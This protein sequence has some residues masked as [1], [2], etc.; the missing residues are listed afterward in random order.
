[1]LSR[2]TDVGHVGKFV[3]PKARVVIDDANSVQRALRQ[4]ITPT[5]IND[6]HL[7][8]A[9]Q[10]YT[11]YQ[12]SVLSPIN[13]RLFDGG[14]TRSSRIHLRRPDSEGACPALCVVVAAVVGVHD[15]QREAGGEA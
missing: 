8:M 1:M 10:N 7:R 9:L 5:Y 12:L 15:G 14:E 4:P 2:L 6:L 3:D 11:I 13:K